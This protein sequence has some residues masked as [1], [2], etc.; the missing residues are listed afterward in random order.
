MSALKL[1]EIQQLRLI[2]KEII[3]GYSFLDPISA[4]IKH[5]SEP[6]NISILKKR[7]DFFNFYVSNGILPEKEKLEIAY[8]TEQWTPIKEE[9]IAALKLRI[10]DNSKM[11]ESIIPQ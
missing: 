3:D 8:L 2:Y 10:K 9:E 1:S 7:Q 11:I 4:Y 6:D 5:L